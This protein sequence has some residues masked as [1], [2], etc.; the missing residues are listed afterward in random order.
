MMEKSELNWLSK[1]ECS[2]LIGVSTLASGILQTRE[3]P[4]SLNDTAEAIEIANK[5]LS[6][7]IK[8]ELDEV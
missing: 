1:G 6:D 7:L 5:V 2:Y 4:A 8:G 3:G